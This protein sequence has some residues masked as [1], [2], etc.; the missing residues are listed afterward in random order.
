MAGFLAFPNE[1][2][3]I[4]GL[5]NQDL[6][7]LSQTSK[8]FRYEFQPLLF[9][10]VSLQWVAN[11]I[12]PP[13]SGFLEAILR[14]PQNAEMVQ[15]LRLSAK[16]Y[17]RWKK[18]KLDYVNNAAKALLDM[19]LHNM[20]TSGLLDENT[21]A[22]HNLLD[23]VIT[24]IIVH[25]PNLKVLHIGT[26]FLHKNVFL[27]RVLQRLDDVRHGIATHSY[28]VLRKVEE[29][30]LLP[31][32]SYG[33][34]SPWPEFPFASYLPFLRSPSLKTVT[35]RFS[36][37][38]LSSD[39]WPTRDLPMHALRKLDLRET[40]VGSSTLT[41]LL[42]QTP[43]LESLQYDYLSGSR[44]G[45]HL[46][47]CTQLRDA[48]RSIAGTLVNLTISSPHSSHEGIGSLRFL[49]NLTK[50]EI[51]LSI[52]LGWQN[53]AGLR[54]AV[55]LPASLKD[56]CLRDDN[57]DC[58]GM[59]W[60]EE[61]TIEEVR[62][63]M[64]MRTKGISTPHVRRF[65]YRMCQ[66]LASQWY[67]H[68]IKSLMKTCKLEGLECWYERA[69][70]QGMETELDAENY[71]L[72]TRRYCWRGYGRWNDDVAVTLLQNREGDSAYE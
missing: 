5:S 21:Q 65:G 48:L 43:R 37:C 30:S 61:Q 3:D 68:D 49:E 32:C 28:K 15:E 36:D 69:D 72:S 54:L 14:S 47:S 18:P 67:G 59:M 2:K 7:Q 8:S 52:L 46:L 70:L 31:E 10:R 71:M 51:P 40:P 35:G 39:V 27:P 44:D 4:I 25:C 9:K 6:I 20:H 26:E 50:L 29:V 12:P 34:G 24:T 1:L 57:I 62:H 60:W 55:A 56:L 64:M 38:E 45:I 42:A 41:S 16:G 19:V 23:I 63:W 53:E 17:E 33:S 22:D 58:K 11:T 13:I 66:D